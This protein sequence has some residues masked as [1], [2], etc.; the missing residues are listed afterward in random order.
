MYATQT[1]VWTMLI[2]VWLTKFRFIFKPSY[3]LDAL[4]SL[5]PT[6]NQLKVPMVFKFFSHICDGASACEL[7]NQPRQS[8]QASCSYCPPTD[9]QWLLFANFGSLWVL[10]HQHPANYPEMLRSS[11]ASL[12]TSQRRGAGVQTVSTCGRTA[13]MPA[14]AAWLSHRW[15][16][17]AT[18][19]L[20]QTLPMRDG[21]LIIGCS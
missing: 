5:I 9:K 12:G 1:R 10:H 14:W 13:Q 8:A 3:S 2:R 16:A 15:T 11:G 7:Q 17:A 6:I 18:K 4:I 20:R 19:L 21:R